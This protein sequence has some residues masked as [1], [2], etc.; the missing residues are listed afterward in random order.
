MQMLQGKTAV[1][2]GASS[3]I[4]LAMAAR[5]SQEGMNVVM[6][7]IEHAALDVATRSMPPARTLAVVTDVSSAQSVEA[8]ADAAR[9][10]FGKVH[11]LCANAGV[12]TY[13]TAWD[14][15]PD[16]W[17]WTINVN[18]WGVVHCVRTFVPGM[19][20]HGEE[21]H[22][23]L[24]SSSEALLAGSSSA[25]GTSKYAVLGLAEGMVRDLA[26]SKIG[27]SVLC[28][29]GVKTKIFE[30]Q[31]NRPG[32]LGM[33]GA[34]G[35]E[36]QRGLEA[37]TN[38]NRTDQFPPSEIADLVLK[39]ILD[40]QLYILPMQQRYQG[41]IRKRLQRLLEALDAAPTRG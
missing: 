41:R 33:R 30:S 19:L 31:R 9:N 32:Q 14:Q 28:P 29:G 1:I 8:L 38:P 22:V 23:V 36:H 24:T 40:K 7:D 35:P 18:L 27:V 12:A 13:G 26:T 34:L 4:G 21:G 2:T 5:F 11:L 6:A 15:S 39:A 17:T 10:A 37:A 20:A 25:Y 3:G 16:D